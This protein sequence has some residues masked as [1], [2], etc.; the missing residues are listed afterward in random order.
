VIADFGLLADE[1]EPLDAVTVASTTTVTAT[2]HVAL[3]TTIK[4][5]E[6]SI[7][8]NNE[9]A[10]ESCNNDVK[11]ETPPQEEQVESWD[12]QKVM[13]LADL[14]RTKITTC[15]APGCDLAAAVVYQSTLTKQNWYSCLDCQE[16]DY[17]GWPDKME[18]LPIQTMTEE[19]KTLMTTKCSRQIAP[20]FPFL[21]TKTDSAANTNGTPTTSTSITTSTRTTTETT[22]VTTLPPTPMEDTPEEPQMEGWDLRKVMSVAE[23]SREGTVKCS[24]ETCVLAAAVVY[25]S[26]LTK[27]KW[28]SCLDCQENDYGGWPDKM[29]ELPIQTMTEEHKTLMTNKCSRRSAPVFP[30]FSDETSPCKPAGTTNTLTPP[31]NDAKQ[32]TPTPGHNKK[33]Q[34]S[35][36]AM[37]IHRK[38]Q[39]AAEALG[40]PDARIVVDKKDAKKLIFGLLYDAF[41]PMNITQIHTALKAVVPSPVLKQCLDDMALDGTHDGNTFVDSDDEDENEN[42]NKNKG[43][44]TK[45]STDEFAGLLAFKPGRN[46]NTSL[47]YVDHTK[48]KNNGNGLDP[49]A[50]NQLYS[51]KAKAEHEHARLKTELAQM[52]ADTN[53]LNSEPTNEEATAKLEVEE[54]DMTDLREKVEEARKLKVNEKH[55]K[56]TKR[57]I[58][59]MAAQ[60]RKRRRICLEFLSNMEECTD[61]SITRKACLKGDGPI[62]IDSDEKAI[63][64][65]KNFLINQ[66]A[67]KFSKSNKKQD[68]KIAAD[69][70]FIG[71]ELD[72]QGK[73]LR[74]YMQQE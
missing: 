39:A 28:Y 68:D 64:D 10:E 69:E 27:E 2:S 22:V 71:V 37:A 21:E 52:V 60:W 72:S 1:E 41:T 11:D 44:K 19:H 12:L 25:Q 6:T 3:T 29:D 36:Q 34:P 18:E 62:D 30:A 53:R 7:N 15:N 17:G 40:G 58:E 57:R 26:T 8:E 74:V 61:G 50:R 43:K 66:R 24:T 73:V 13:S 63:Q 16:A 9:R 65:A 35:A 54:S 47:Y 46:G 51:D 5:Q 67:R 45:E 49:E 20:V 55:K 4:E 38:W 23:L 70:N 32:V 14:S 31:P 48:Q 42:N 33:T 59:N 56:Q